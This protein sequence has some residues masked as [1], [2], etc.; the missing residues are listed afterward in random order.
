[1][2]LSLMVQLVH[3]SRLISMMIIHCDDHHNDYEGVWFIGPIFSHIPIWVF[4]HFDTCQKALKD[5]NH[6]WIYSPNIQIFVVQITESILILTHLFTK[7][8]ILTKCRKNESRCGWW[9][10]FIDQKRTLVAR[11]SS[12][13]FRS[14]KGRCALVCTYHIDVSHESTF[15]WEKLLVSSY[16]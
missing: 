6:P 15:S 10:E 7:A 2:I 13:L 5:S 14:C 11:G 12:L 4:L 1:M 9:V 8:P 3:A 16:F